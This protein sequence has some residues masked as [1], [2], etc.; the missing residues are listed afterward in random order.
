MSQVLTVWNGLNPRRRVIVVVATLAVF[1]AVLGLARMAAKPDLALL[2]SGLD[3]AAAGQVVAALERA[4]AAHE[5]RGAAIYVDAAARDSLRMTLASEGLPPASARGYELLDNLS[6]FSTTAQM[7]DV[8]YWRAK[9]GELA[10]TILANPAFGSARVH[11]AVPAGVPFRRESAPSAAVTVRPVSGGVA[12][13]QARALRFL[14]AAAVPG[15]L[16]DAVSVI[17]AESGLVI[18][19]DDIG[20]MAGDPAGREAALRQNVERLLAARLGPGRSVVEVTVE[21]VTERESIMERRVD[22][23]SRVAIS[24]DTEE[25]TS[26]SEDS[27]PPPVTVASNLPDGDAQAGE[28][29]SSSNSSET[30]ERVNYEVSETQREVVRVPGATKRVSVAVLVDGVRSTDEQGNPI[31]APLPDDELGAL[32]ELVASAVGY[33]EARGDVITIRSMQFEP[34]APLGTLAERGFLERAGLDAM[35]LIQLGV[36]AL[37]ALLLGL[38]VIRPILAGP[39]PLPEGLPEAPALPGAEGLVGELT[40]PGAADENEALALAQEDPVMRLRRLM[41]E[42]REQGVEVLRAWIE[43]QEEGAR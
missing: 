35:S 8:A 41:E 16:P 37:V 5:V 18:G 30:R 38:F 31:W 11:L 23:E 13:A 15:L 32:R 2:Y 24:S 19:A 7:F 42:R 39:A 4:G 17:D 20:A 9:E 21:Q 43:Q 40:G 6:G 28:R 25:T 29:Q 22:P 36:L 34:V 3:P 33:D 26:T 27:G 10:R 14:V 1:A 12:P